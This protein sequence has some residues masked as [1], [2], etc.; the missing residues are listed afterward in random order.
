MTA[1]PATT[2]AVEYPCRRHCRAELDLTGV[3]TRFTHAQ[4][5]RACDDLHK[6]LHESGRLELSDVAGKVTVCGMPEPADPLGVA[7]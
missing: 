6:R 5:L 1:T 2:F 4:M 7:S 3:H